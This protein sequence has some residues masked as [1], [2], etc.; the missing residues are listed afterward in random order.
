MPNV[1]RPSGF[2]P[3]KH[4]DGSAWNGATE[5]FA[6]LAADATVLQ[7]GDLVL[8]AGNADANGVASVTKITNGTTSVPLGAVVG[9][10]PDYS[11]L[12]IPSEA[13]AAS[14]LRYVNV[15]ID[16]TVVYEAQASGTYVVATDAGLNAGVTLTA[17]PAT[18]GVSAM[19]ID[20]TTKATTAT[21]PVKILGLAQ[22]ADQDFSDT[23]NLKVYC[24]VNNQTFSNG[25]LG[26]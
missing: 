6:H 2:R 10:L 13:V 23:S 17:G 8:L 4:I 20:M 22:R 16:P 11:N 25:T 12:N 19:Q 26:V 18:T 14:T 7:V 24:L 1:S 15:C 9:F 5:Q 21:L 3:V